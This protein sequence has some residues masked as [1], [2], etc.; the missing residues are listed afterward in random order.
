M[1]KYELQYL[2]KQNKIYET[3][4]IQQIIPKKKLANDLTRAKNK[5]EYF[6]A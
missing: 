3:T 2:K 4:T 6:E 5:A 1:M